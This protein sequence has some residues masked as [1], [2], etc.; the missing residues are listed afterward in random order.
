MAAQ[1]TTPT[2]DLTISPSTLEQQLQETPQEILLWSREAVFRLARL[3]AAKNQLKLVEARCA[4]D[5]RSNPL[6][7]GHQKVTEGLIESLVVVQEEYQEAQEAVRTAEA[8]LGEARAVVD[9]LESKRSSLKYLA[10]LTVSGY[11]G[12][13]TVSVS[14]PKGVRN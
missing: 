2:L 1:D 5:I 6:S 12:S 8:S 13:T 3:N 4:L 7:Y 10:E 14:P 9:A 11:L